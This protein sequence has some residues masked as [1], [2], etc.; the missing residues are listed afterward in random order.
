MTIISN[1]GHD[2]NGTYHG[3]KAGDQ[4]GGEWTLRNW[5]NRPWKCVLRHPDSTVRSMIANMAREAANNDKIGYD[6]YQRTSFWT[7]LKK[8]KYRPQDINTVCEADCSSGVA[9]IIKGAGYRLAGAKDLIGV[10]TDL[11][12]GNMRSA[13]KK[14]GFTVLTD[15]KYLTTSDYLL[16]GDILLNDEHHVCINVSDGIKS[17]PSTTAGATSAGHATKSITT[18]ANEVIDGKWGVGEDRVKKLKAAGYDPKKVQDKVNAIL[19]GKKSITT[20]AKEVIDGKWGNG[21]TREKR[22][23]A[24]GYD[25]KAVQKKVNELLK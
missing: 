20:I 1:C 22:L 21:E 10:S 7:Q 3:G 15:S 23:K 2:E 25:Y 5:Y 16:K 6:Q 13:L 4:T 18:I 12:T 11:W 24:A 14:A 9:A 19:S 17:K 8:A